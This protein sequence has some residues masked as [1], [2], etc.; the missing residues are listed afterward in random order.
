MP[1]GE[2]ERQI[3]DRLLDEGFDAIQYP[4]LVAKIAQ[5]IL[6]AQRAEREACAKIA[7]SYPSVAG[8]LPGK[9][10]A[11]ALRQRTGEGGER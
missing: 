6:A 11:A 1:R 5:L 9:D 4:G 3:E 7:E 2:V 10:I 8:S